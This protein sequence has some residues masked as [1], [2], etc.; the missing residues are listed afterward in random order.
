MIE[1]TLAKATLTRPFFVAATVG[2]FFI[3]FYY[4]D[5]GQKYSKGIRGAT[6]FEKWFF[7]IGGIVS[8]FFIG[9]L[10]GVVL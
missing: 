6:K 9:S 1:E 5:L 4:M 7:W 3:F 8:G 2:L 10:I